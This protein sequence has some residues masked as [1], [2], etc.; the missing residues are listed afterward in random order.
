M[1]ETGLSP[2]LV[3][4]I[5]IVIG[6]ALALAVVVAQMLAKV[7]DKLWPRQAA[8][9]EVIEKLDAIADEIKV[10][11]AHMS[12]KIESAERVQTAAVESLKEMA[13]AARSQQEVARGQIQTLAKLNDGMVVLLERSKRGRSS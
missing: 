7:L 6:A 1:E 11:N 4:Q 12:E 2:D 10:G 9:E 8:S 3:K 13:V 5:L